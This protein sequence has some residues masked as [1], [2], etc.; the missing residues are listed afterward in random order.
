M[1]HIA[2]A[3]VVSVLAACTAAFVAIYAD[4]YASAAGVLDVA[5]S[6][7]PLAPACL[8]AGILFQLTLNTPEMRREQRREKQQ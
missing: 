3:F 7:V 1:T 8:F 2:R 4:L 5:A 6:L